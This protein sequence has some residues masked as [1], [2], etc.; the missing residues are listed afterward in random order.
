MV[1]LTVG[2]AKTNLF[3]ASIGMANWRYEGTGP[4]GRMNSQKI[5]VKI[6]LKIGLKR[7]NHLHFWGVESQKYNVL[8]D[9][10]VYRSI[11]GVLLDAHDEI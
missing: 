8:I 1:G 9:S 3:Q 6:E 5:E 10:M 11:D 7:V 2:F 4:N